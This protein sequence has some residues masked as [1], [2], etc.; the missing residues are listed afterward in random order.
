MGEGVAPPLL[1]DIV[2]SLEQ[3]RRQ[4]QG[5]EELEIERLLVHGVAHLLGHDHQNDHEAECMESLERIL[6]GHI[7]KALEHYVSASQSGNPL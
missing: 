2:I 5:S 1:G 7:S 3:V 4:H 6:A